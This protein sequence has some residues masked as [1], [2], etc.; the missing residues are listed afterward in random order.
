MINKSFIIETEGNLL[1]C[2][3]HIIGHQV[4]CK[5]I[6]GAGLA[7][8]IRRQFPHVYEDYVQYCRN[9]HYDRSL[10]GSCHI[11]EAIP[12]KK[13]VAH[14]FGQFGIGRQ[15]RQTDYDALKNALF[16]LKQFAQK[17][18]LSVALPYEL[19]CGLGGGSWEI[20]RSIIEEVFDDYYVTIYRL[21]SKKQELNR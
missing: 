13:W 18:G 15:V 7:K 16:L 10:M 21:P 11:S 2:K 9:H 5:G 8:Q 6:M 1:T 4:N 20:V 12:E 17:E 19:G 14:L 3:E